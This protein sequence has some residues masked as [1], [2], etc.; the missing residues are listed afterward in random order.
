MEHIGKDR[1]R[2]TNS[3]HANRFNGKTI[4]KAA[5]GLSFNNDDT[6][7]HTFSVDWNKDRLIYYVD[8]KPTLIYE[9]SNLPM[10]NAT[11]K[12]AWA[13]DCDL[14]IILNTAL[15]MWNFISFIEPRILSFC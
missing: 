15:G 14:Y 9:K 4:N 1:N 12:V 11:D 13:F 8:D 10:F 3:V 5:V 6:T 2:T 7:F